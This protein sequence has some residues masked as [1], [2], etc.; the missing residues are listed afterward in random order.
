M[1]IYI[2][3]PPIRLHG[4]VLNLLSI[5]TTLPLLF[6]YLKMLQILFTMEETLFLLPF[7]ISQ[8]LTLHFYIESQI[9]LQSKYKEHFRSL[10]S[11][12][13]FIFITPESIHAPKS[14]S[15][16]GMCCHRN[17]QQDARMIDYFS[18]DTRFPDM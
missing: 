7:L 14:V 13:N 16:A 17:K 2:S 3:T 5:G 12:S 4:V 15:R 18:Q 11:V 1:W 9:L 10:N 6:T 8:F